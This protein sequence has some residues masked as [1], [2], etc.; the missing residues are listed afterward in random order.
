MT[1]KSGSSSV[2]DWVSSLFQPDTLLSEQYLETCRRKTHLEPEI[3]LMLAVLEDA[4]ACFQKYVAA[5]RRKEKVLFQEAE[6]WFLEKDSDSFYSFENICES[7]GLDPDYL[8]KGLV[9][10]KEGQV[11][12]KAKI[13][14]LNPVQGKN[15]C[16]PRRSKPST[17]KLRELKN[18]TK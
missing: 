3:R 15:N 17:H 9:L 1:T 18:G 10:W 7:L 2:N 14:H 12:P 6:E 5:Q 11:R 8:R 13:Y 16:D 4:V